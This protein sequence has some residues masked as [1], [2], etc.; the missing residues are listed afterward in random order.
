MISRALF[1]RP[2]LRQVDD[3]LTLASEQ[4]HSQRWFLN[5][6]RLQSDMIQSV[7]V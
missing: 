5:E 6:D 3:Y 4:F 1:S 7:W 2:I